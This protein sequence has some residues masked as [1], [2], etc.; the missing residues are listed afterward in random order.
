MKGATNDF[1]H[2]G[3]EAGGTRTVAILTDG[4][5]ACLGRWEFGPANMRLLT[6]EELRER[7]AEAAA[8]AG[9]VHSVGVGMAGARDERD[10]TKIRE[11]LELV[12]PGI[13]FGVGHDL[14]SALAA[15]GGEEEGLARVVVLSGTGSCCYGRSAAG[16]TA[17]VGGWGHLIGDKGSGYELGLRALK[18]SV[19]YLDRDGVWGEL[20]RR[21]LRKLLL[22]EPNDLIAW[23]Q[24]AD[25]R[26]IAA[27]AIEVFEAAALKD[28]IAKDILQGAAHS[29]AKDAVTCA[30]RLAR[31]GEEVRFVFAGSV[32]TRQPRFAASVAQLIRKAWPKGRV[33]KLTMEGA[34]GAALMGRAAHAAAGSPGRSSGADPSRERVWFTPGLRPLSPTEERNPR[35]MELDRWTVEE[36]VGRFIAEDARIPAALEAVRPQI[37]KLVKWVTS[38]FKRGGRLIYIGAGTSGRLGVLDASECPPTF[39]AAPEMVQGIIAG[40]QTALWS[41]AEGAEDDPKAG[42]EAVGF[43]DVGRLD[44]VVG[45]AASGRT[46]FVWGGL[47][48]ARS[49]GAKTALVCMNP[50]LEI[51]ARQRPGVVIAPDVGPELLTGSTRLKSGT[52]TKLI[53][54]MVTTLAMVGNGKVVGN[55]MV[56]LN[57]SNVKLRYRAARIVG[58]LAGCGPEAA[59]EALVRSGWVVK[60]ALASL[61]RSPGKGGTKRVDPKAFRARGGR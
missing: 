41:P 21:I 10:Q 35:S 49:R 4:G 7:F 26:A 14:D 34:F 23:A 3:I 58:E 55:L 51:P 61:G 37:V 39:R 28:K 9:P 24:R 42:A 48:E 1:R 17:K 59:Q 46:P 22:N 18:A 5:C 52:A 2:L 57:P 30:R 31:S 32:L 45:I 36:A 38:A 43:R 25:K 11:I 27:L 19:Y 50:R 47:A 20:G 40:G 53:L 8:V 6:P 16:E 60:K 13:P 33:G 15:A 29:L 12:W 56:D 44:V 54:N